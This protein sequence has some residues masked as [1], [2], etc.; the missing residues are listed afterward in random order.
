ML[1]TDL[2]MRDGVFFPVRLID[3]FIVKSDSNHKVC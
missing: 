2:L 1:Q 3:I